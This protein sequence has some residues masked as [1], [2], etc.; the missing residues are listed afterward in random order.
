[1]RIDRERLLP[2]DT[3]LIG[4]DGTK[5]LPVRT[6]TLPETIGIYP[7]QLTREV[8][9]LVIDCTSAYNAIIGQPTL[10]AWK[11]TTST[12]H[13]LVKFPTKNGIGKAQGSQMATHECYVSMLEVDVHLQALNIEERKVTIEPME[14]LLGW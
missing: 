5:V 1:M 10:N 9:F 3:S 12:Y 6:I 4:F 13:L 14:D 7:Q 2:S 11:A 8:S